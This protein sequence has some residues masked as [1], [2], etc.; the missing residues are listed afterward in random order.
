MMYLLEETTIAS[1]PFH[2]GIWFGFRGISFD[3][4]LVMNIADIVHDPNEVERLDLDAIE[5]NWGD[6]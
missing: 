3:L 2:P 1:S 4:N 6:L 5:F